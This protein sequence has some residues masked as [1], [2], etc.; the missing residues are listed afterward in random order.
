MKIIFQI[1]LLGGFLFITTQFAYSCSCLRISNK[2][3]IKRTDMIFTGEVTEITQNTTYIPPK[4]EN[5]SPALQQ[6]VNTRKRY[7]VKFK[8]EKGFKNINGDE[9]T[10]AQYEDEFSPCPGLLFTKGNKYLVYA[11]Q[12]KDEI[13]GGGICSRT[14]PF[15]EKSEDY[16]ELLQRR[17]KSKN[18]KL[19]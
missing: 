7:L 15:D 16:K 3:E 5:I 12:G 13:S 4:I 2:A 10:L 8:V 9:I 19:A 17:L 11:L 6:R 18:K 14:Q 1:C